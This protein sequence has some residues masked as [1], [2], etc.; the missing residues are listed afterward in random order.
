M[1]SVIVPVRKNLMAALAA[2]PAFANVET[3]FAYRVGTKARQRAWTQNATFE[4]SSAGMRAVK[5]FRNELGAFNLV[6]RVEGVALAPEDTATRAA[7]IG[8]AA[9]DWIATKAHWEND[10]LVAGLNWLVIEGGGA[11]TEAFNDNG[12]LADLVYPVKYQARL[13]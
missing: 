5:T 8:L 3:V 10:A 9:E 2:L 4:H 11:L 7:A 1:G 13:T 6:I 12:S